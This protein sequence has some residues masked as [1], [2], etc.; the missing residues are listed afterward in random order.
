MPK[1]RMQ[2]IV[3]T[4]RQKATL[5]R[6][7]SMTTTQ[8]RYRQRVQ[9]VLNALTEKPNTMIA[10]KMGVTRAFVQRWLT[11]WSFAKNELTT[12]DTEEKEH[13]YLTGVLKI[14][15]DEARAGAP[16]KFT[17]E[18]VCNVIAIACESPEESGYPVSHW[19]RILIVQEAI[20]R[21][22][23]K[24]ISKTQV[25]RF[26]KSG[27]PQAAQSRRLDTYTY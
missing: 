5:E 23:V 15:T 27:R 13:K 4:E 12:L 20:K 18:E 6:I 24:T 3:V 14:F 22:I 16:A 19:S 21:K 25:G 10:K 11:R 2:V 17:A 9:V 26:L 7:A 1:K 8:Y